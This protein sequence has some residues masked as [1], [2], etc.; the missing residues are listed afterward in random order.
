[1]KRTAVFFLLLTVYSLKLYSQGEGV[2]TFTTI[3]QSPLLLGSGQIG[4]S[5]PNDDVLGFYFNPAILGHSARQNHSSIS[6]MPDKT[7]WSTFWFNNNVN[8]NNYGINLGYNLKSTKLEL[9]IS[10]G[11][12]FLHSKIDFG[13]RGITSEFGPEI[14]KEVES[15]DL[16][17][18]FSLG[19]GFDYYVKINF[20]IS[21][22]SFV[23]Q[24]GGKV[25]NDQFTNFS[26]DGTMLDYGG[27]I[28]LPIYELIT[29]DKKYQLEN[30]LAIKPISNFSIGYATANIGDEVEYVDF[31]KDPLLRTARL[32][33]T[34]ELGF[35]LLLNKAKINF[36]NYSF[37]AEAQDILIKP[38]DQSNSGIKYQSGLGD[39]DISNNLIKLKEDNK[40][41]VHRGHIFK[42]FDTL[43]LT[44]GR[45]AGRGYNSSRVTDGIGFTSKGLFNFMNALS[46]NNIIQF[47]AKH[48]VIEYFDANV[49]FF[50]N[51][52]TNFD[53]LSIHF[54][55]FEL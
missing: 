20:G 41:I 48:F 40:V 33:Y 11:I 13:N 49:E 28:T 35:D 24:I 16:F 55:G 38:N 5:I 50:T 45:F 27:L 54:V 34:F 10:I 21:L 26:I 15:Y 17:N 53:A 7:L 4:V 2:M 36:V 44:S 31:Q 30:A 39:I 42:F 52:P 29:Q 19:I 32:G 43:I 1:M 46:N 8:F 47:I 51:T 25:T 9:P 22:K 3:Q 14:I 37:T 12:G 23:S 18:S 6:I